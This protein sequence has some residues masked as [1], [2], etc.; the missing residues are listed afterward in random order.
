MEAQRNFLKKEKGKKKVMEEK[1]EKGKE[2]RANQ[3][4]RKSGERE[5]CWYHF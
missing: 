2:N 1:E 5:V 3:E 4:N